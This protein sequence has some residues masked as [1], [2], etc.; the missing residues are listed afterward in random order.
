SQGVMTDSTPYRP[1][2]CL[3]L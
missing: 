3:S 2:I 1:L